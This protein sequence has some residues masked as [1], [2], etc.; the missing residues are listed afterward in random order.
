MYLIIIIILHT[1]PDGPRGPP[2]PPGNLTGP[3]SSSYFHSHHHTIKCCELLFN[4]QNLIL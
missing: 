4:Y 3:V 1:D 2:G